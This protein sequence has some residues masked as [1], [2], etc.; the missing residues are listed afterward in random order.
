MVYSVRI[1]QEWRNGAYVNQGRIS[2]IVRD[3]QGQHAAYE[4][5]SWSYGAW[6][7]NLRYSTTYLPNRD[8]QGLLEQRVNNAWVPTYRST[9]SYDQFSTETGYTQES[10]IDGAWIISNAYRYLTRYNASNDLVSRV[11]QYYNTTTKV[12]ENI[13]K[14]TYGDYQSITLGR[15]LAPPSWLISSCILILP[16]VT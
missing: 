9:Y 10:Y 2:N 11:W 14:N 13:S 8:T 3:S 4:L 16:P 5:E 6:E 7:A 1:T 12:Y 15:S